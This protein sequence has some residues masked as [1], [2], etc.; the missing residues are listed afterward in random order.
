[1]FRDFGAGGKLLVAGVT[2]LVA[3]GVVAMGVVIFRREGVAW[4]I[5]FVAAAVIGTAIRVIS[6]RGHLPSKRRPR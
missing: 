3:V 6:V 1:V 4:L 2:A 5:A